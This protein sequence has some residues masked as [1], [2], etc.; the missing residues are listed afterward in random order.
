MYWRNIAVVLAVF[1]LVLGV[2]A[3]NEGRA[4]R[5]VENELSA[6]Y[7]QSFYESLGHV[8]NVEV[9]LSKGI[10]ASTPTQIADIFSQL[11]TSALAAQAQITNLP[12]LEGTIMRTGKFLTQVGDF[13]LMMSRKA[14]G[15]TPPDE[16]D[17]TLLD[18]LKIEAAVIN[19]ALH[20]IQ[21]DVADGKIAWEEIRK[22]SNRRLS[23]DSQ[24]ID[25]GG[26]TPLESHFENIPVIVYDGPF[27]DHILSTKP[28]ELTGAEIDENE[29]IAI[30][31]RFVPKRGEETAEASVERKVDGMIPAMTVSVGAPAENNGSGRRAGQGENNNP[32]TVMDVSIRGGHVVWMMTARRSLES[33]INMDEATQRGEQF[34]NERGYENMVPRLISRADHTA[35]IPFVPEKEGVLL[36]PD[37][38][39]VTVAMDD[40]EVIGYEASAYILN[41]EAERDISR[42]KLTEK[43]AIARVAPSLTIRDGA[44]L[45]LIP[46]PMKQEALTWEIVAEGYGERYLIYINAETGE[47]EALYRIVTTGEGEM[48]I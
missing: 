1:S 43:E 28:K 10:A 13:G 5:R 37:Q 6:R 25:Q 11:R 4:R 3:F 35:V 16:K 15:G 18:Q 31:N 34:L 44:R 48:A 36:Y 47:E 20:K 46:T 14:A 42:P 32:R 22:T 26:F 9:L 29:A 38:V 41:H 33:R 19:D 40:G 30:A 21:R 12:L 45:A 2:F 17:V 24:K 8:E 27:S 23:Q 7:R 39:K